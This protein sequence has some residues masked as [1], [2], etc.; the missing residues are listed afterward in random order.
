MF[1]I[2]PILVKYVLILFIEKIYVN[3]DKYIP[4][5]NFDP[6]IGSNFNFSTRFYKPYFFNVSKCIP[7]INF[8]PS[9]ASNFNFS[10][11]FYK[12]YFF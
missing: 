9:I 1:W 2:D 6:S 12:P 5:I 10:T 7:D 8:D 4:G 11:R 3:V